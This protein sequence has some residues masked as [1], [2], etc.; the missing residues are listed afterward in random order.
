[1]WVVILDGLVITVASGSL[2]LALSSLSRRSI[3][4]GLAWGGFVFERP[5]CSDISRLNSSS[6]S[7]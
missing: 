7:A 3:Y 2:M 6:S 4:V 5:R 1:L